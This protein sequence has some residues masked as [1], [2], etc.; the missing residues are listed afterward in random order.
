V[1]VRGRRSANQ[2]C[3]FLL[4]YLFLLLEKQPL[5]THKYVIGR[6]LLACALGGLSGSASSEA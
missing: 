6:S 5:V 3:L 1:L 2:D 4:F